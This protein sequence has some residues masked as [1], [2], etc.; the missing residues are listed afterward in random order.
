MYY[1]ARARARCGIMEKLGVRERESSRGILIDTITRLFIVSF[2]PRQ[3][4]SVG[5]ACKKGAH[6]WMARCFFFF[7]FGRC[8]DSHYFLERLLRET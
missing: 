7:F 8:W 6:C 3:F 1:K 2:I 4:A 5:R